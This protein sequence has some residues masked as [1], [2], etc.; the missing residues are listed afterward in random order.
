MVIVP[1]VGDS[2]GLSSQDGVSQEEE[3]AHFN[4]P[5]LNRLHET[6]IVWGEDSSNVAV[7]VIPAQNKV[8]LQILSGTAF[9]T[10]T[11]E[12]SVLH[13]EKVSRESQEE[14]TPRH[15]L[16]FKPMSWLG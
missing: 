3:E 6:Y 5:K 12:D 7:T 14:D 13:T 8:T 11:V 16:W 9:L 1:D 4:I 15:V 2:G 10:A